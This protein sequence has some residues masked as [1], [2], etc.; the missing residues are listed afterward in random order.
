[1]TV[2]A[3]IGLGFRDNPGDINSN[4]ASLVIPTGETLAL[5]GGNLNF[6]GGKIEIFGGR[7][8]L[9][10]LTESG[11]VDINNDGSFNFPDAVA[12][13]NVSFTNTAQVIV[14]GSGGGSININASNLSLTSGSRFFAG[15]FTETGSPDAQ[16]GDVVIDLTEDL[17]LDN[18]NI[19]NAIFSEIGNA[20]NVIVD[21]RN[22]NF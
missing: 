20:G 2:N 18:S 11:V 14:A 9:G 21:A 6:D 10:G 22:I 17:V 4:Q 5:L 7:V 12:R 16:A 8:E 13:G 1:M 19:T 15:I 3:P